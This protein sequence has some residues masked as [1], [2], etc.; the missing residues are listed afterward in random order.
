MY[1]YILCIPFKTFLKNLWVA[2]SC[3]SHWSNFVDSVILPMFTAVCL[4][5]CILLPHCLLQP[6][7]KYSMSIQ[8]YVYPRLFKSLWS[9]S[10][11]HLLS[12]L[13]I[14]TNFSRGPSIAPSLIHTVKVK[15][16]FKNSKLSLI[17]QFSSSKIELLTNLLFSKHTLCFIIIDQNY[18]S[19][20]SSH[21][22][23]T[24]F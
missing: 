8:E 14:L 24:K 7:T 21:L 12:L 1:H 23:V 20:T 11:I 9:H 4:C 13:T 6:I 17:L 22:F 2:N 19:I 15:W 16:V 5:S 3:P 18:T 10:K